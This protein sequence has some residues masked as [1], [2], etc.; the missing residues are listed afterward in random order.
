MIWQGISLYF[1]ISDALATRRLIREFPGAVSPEVP[2]Q[3]LQQ[4]PTT[5]ISLREELDLLLG[6]DMTSLLTFVLTQDYSAENILFL[7][8]IRTW[9]A[10][11]FQLAP[12]FTNTG[13]LRK[14]MYDCAIELYATYI[15]IHSANFPVNLESAISYALDSMFSDAMLLSRHTGSGNNIAPFESISDIT[16]V[17]S[18][19]GTPTPTQMGSRSRRALRRQ[20]I[21]DFGAS[22][23]GVMVE[24]YIETMLADLKRMSEEPRSVSEDFGIPDGFNET[25]FD[26]AER[27]V[28]TL[29]LR[30]TWPKYRRYEGLRVTE[31]RAVPA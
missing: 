21:D 4:G 31:R 14:H 30:D 27:S 3:R 9:K 7:H 2:F 8:Q 18:E 17:N 19:S 25:V 26:E 12:N 23:S 5:A 28:K 10:K 29:V 20:V 6:G 13:S 24:R 15:N 22:F 1:P 16:L 11:W